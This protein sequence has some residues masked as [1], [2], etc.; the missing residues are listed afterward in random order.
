MNSAFSGCLPLK[1]SWKWAIWDYHAHSSQIEENTAKSGLEC[2]LS[3][4][5]IPV[6]VSL[7]DQARAMVLPA[8]SQMTW[9][10]K[11]RFQNPTL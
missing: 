9:I 7:K 3:D 1:T 10:H 11:F 2:D 4:F 8:Q 6:S 5:S